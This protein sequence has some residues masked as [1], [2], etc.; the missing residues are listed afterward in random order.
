[1]VSESQANGRVK[2]HT[3]IKQIERDL[4]SVDQTKPYVQGDYS[5]CPD[6]SDEEEEVE[7]DWK[8]EEEDGVED[9]L[10][11]ED[12]LDVEDGIDEMEIGVEDEGDENILDTE[13]LDCA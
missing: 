2:F 9:N 10:G 7:E 5:W 11:E 6:D 13:M 4:N 8:E 12:D 1:M 3:K